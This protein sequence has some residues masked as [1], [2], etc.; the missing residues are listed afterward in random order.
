MARLSDT[1]HALRSALGNLW[2]L[3]ELAQE[4]IRFE[5]GAAGLAIW[6]RNAVDCRRWIAVATASGRGGDLPPALL[7]NR[8]YFNGQGWAIPD[9]KSKGDTWQS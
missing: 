3:D 2:A 5:G 4:A 6:L 7:H 1:E 9:V 8:A